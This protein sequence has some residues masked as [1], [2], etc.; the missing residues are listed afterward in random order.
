M[1][2]DVHNDKYYECEEPRHAKRTNFDMD[3]EEMTDEYKTIEE[4]QLIWAEN[5]LT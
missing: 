5:E 2:N 1:D 3:T 4:Y